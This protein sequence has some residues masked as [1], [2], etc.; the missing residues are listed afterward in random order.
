VPTG[1]TPG[2]AGPVAIEADEALILRCRDASAEE[3]KTIVGELA[4]RHHRAVVGFIHGI[5]NDGTV[6]EDLAQ[7]AFVRVYRHAREWEEGAAKFTTWLFTIAR[8]LSLNEIRD[9]KKRPKL[10]LDG[11][12]ENDSQDG[13]GA[14]VPAAGETPL[15]QV[16]RK[17]VAEVV[18]RAVMELPDGFR[19]V[20]VLCDLEQLSYE[21]CAEALSIPIGTVRSRLSR[22]R[23]HLSDRLRAAKGSVA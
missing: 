3:V 1:E 5:V 11:K 10:A 15:A 7:E 6:A 13:L 16:A 9:R 23:G 18:R 14:S 22:A 8:N 21:E 4:R 20:L 12:S 17:D 2:A 19:Q